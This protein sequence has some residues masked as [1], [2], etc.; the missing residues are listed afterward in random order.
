MLRGFIGLIDALGVRAKPYLAQIAA[1][2]KWRIQNKSAQVRLQVCL[3]AYICM[4]R[5]TNV[6]NKS[7]LLI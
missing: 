2:A 5:Y 7:R 6:K 1:T 3:H 4:C